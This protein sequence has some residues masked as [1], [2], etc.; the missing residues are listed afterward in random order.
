MNPPP[1]KI[2]NEWSFRPPLKLFIEPS[3]RISNVPKDLTFA[4][5]VVTIMS[6]VDPASYA[7]L[8]NYKEGTFSTTIRLSKDELLAVERSGNHV[9][10]SLN[11][12]HFE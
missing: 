4:D 7:R 11:V 2:G 1:V 5:A 8:I 10:V 3:G 6:Y 12:E 9:I